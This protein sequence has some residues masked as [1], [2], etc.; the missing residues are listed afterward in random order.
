[1]LLPVDQLLSFLSMTILFVC[2]FEM[3]IIFCLQLFREVFEFQTAGSLKK[4][5]C[6]AGHLFVAT[7]GCKQLTTFDTKTLDDVQV[8]EMVN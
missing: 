4:V 2:A 5:W 3:H 6:N 7:S 8:L 1:M